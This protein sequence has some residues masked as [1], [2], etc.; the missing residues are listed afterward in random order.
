MSNK[1]KLVGIKAIS[2]DGDGTLWDFE[3]VMQ[4]SLKCV[5]IELEQID[6]KTARMLDI[7]RMIKIRNRVAN[8]LKG[9]ITNLE[10][11]R[12]IA[13]Q[14]TLKDIGKPNNDLAFH[15]NQ[16][17]RKHRFEDI[18]LYYDVLPTLKKLNKKYTIGLVSNGNSY[19]KYCGLEGIFSFVIFSQDYKVEKPDQKI[20]QIAV[21]KAGCLKQEIVH[22]G[23][24][25][26]SDIIGAKNAGIKSVWI[27]R[28][29]L[30]NKLGIKVDYEISSLLDLL[31]ILS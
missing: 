10:K 16:I 15:L 31:E 17:Y 24:S 12:L 22:V 20:F 23:D 4:Q 26:E 19:P 14:E 11:I 7:D 8:Y 1:D 27:N 29:K 2:F 13:F 25:L 3:K 5:L 9:K 6:S 21:E 28:N 30:E 18:E